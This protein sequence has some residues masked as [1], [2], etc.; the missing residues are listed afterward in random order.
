MVRVV[1]QRANTMVTFNPPQTGCGA[2]LGI[3]QHCD[4]WIS[5]DVQVSATEPILV[6]HYLASN[7]GS[8]PDAGDPSVAFAVPTEQY[9]NEYT[10]LVPSQY[11]Q[12]FLSLVAPAG[13][14]VSI[15]GV[16]VTAQLATFGSG[17]FAAGRVAT[18]AGQHRVLCSAGCGIEIYGWSNAV[19]YLV[20]AGLDLEQIVVVE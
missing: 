5:G 18:T 6:G 4:V 20:A 17:Q 8:D 12:S 15:D 1:A 3:G 14:S 19:S 13:G 2:A 9:R 7:G 11:A 16:D 10:L